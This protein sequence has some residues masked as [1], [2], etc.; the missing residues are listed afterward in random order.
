MLVIK[1]HSSRIL[2]KNKWESLIKAHSYNGFIRIKQ[3]DYD[4]INV[5]AKKWR[6]NGYVG[7]WGKVWL[8][9]TSHLKTTKEKS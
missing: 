5:T 3:T 7:K 6:V 1:V 8:I 4:G 9:D 2:L